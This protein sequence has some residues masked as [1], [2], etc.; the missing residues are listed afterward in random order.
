MNRMKTKNIA[1]NAYNP[2][3]WAGFL[4]DIHTEA[5]TF[6]QVLKDASTTRD[7]SNSEFA[8]L[9][10]RSFRSIHNIERKKVDLSKCVP[11]LSRPST[12]HIKTR[13]TT[14]PFEFEMRVANHDRWPKRPSSARRILSPVKLNDY[15][16]GKRKHDMICVFGAPLDKDA[17]I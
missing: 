15:S 16:D 7:K 9:G 2:K 14:S 12:Q 4:S 8:N 17:L 3:R 1:E 11:R 6:K 13:Q 10:E 5:N